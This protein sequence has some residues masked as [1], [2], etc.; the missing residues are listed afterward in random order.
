MLAGNLSNGYQ[1]S[2]A[3]FSISSGG[4]MSS[5]GVQRMESQMIPTPGF[6][7]NNQSYMNVNSPKPLPQQFDQ[8]Q[9]QLMQGNLPLHFILILKF[10]HVIV[11]SEIVIYLCF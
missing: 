3:N 1:Q 5:M 7:N 2:P 9:R 10:Y 11:T 4:N 6:S 8:H